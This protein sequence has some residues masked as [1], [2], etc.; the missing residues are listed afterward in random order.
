[1]KTDTR[2]GTRFFSL[3]SERK[4][5]GNLEEYY[6]QHQTP[7]AGGGGNHSHNTEA[8]EAQRIDREKN[9]LRRD[10]H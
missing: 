7:G 6:D 8:H 9:V 3:Q 10:N 2:A 4:T 1:M 5:H